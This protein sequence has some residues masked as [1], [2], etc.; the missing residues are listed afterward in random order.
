[1]DGRHR[2]LLVEDS[3][4]QAAKLRAV[5]EAQGWEVVWI[6]T[7]EAAIERINRDPPHLILLDYHLP[8]V[9]GDEFCRRI[10]MNIETRAIPVLML[11]ADDAPEAEVRG[12]ES[13]ADDFAPKSVDPDILTAR[14]RALLT[15]WR[16]GSSVLGRT[17][18]RFRAA[19]ILAIDDSLT[20]LEYLSE[21]LGREGYLLEKA[22][23]GREGLERLGAGAFDCV[24]VDLM[25]PEVDG[26]EVCRRI[27]ESRRSLDDPIA[28]LMLTARETKDDLTRALEAGADDFVGK[29]SDISVI[30]GRIRALLRRKFF[31][32]E[33]RR[34]LEEL[35]NKEMERVRARAEQTAAEAR[36]ALAEEL[37]AAKEAA[38]RADRAK[39]EF[40]SRMSHELRTPLNSILGFGQLLAMDELAGPQRESVD[41]ILKSG[42]HLLNLINEVLDIARIEAGRVHLS[43]EDVR[44]E[45]V[46]AEAATMIAPIA[47]Q[48]GVQLRMPTPGECDRVVRADVQR[49]KQAVLNLLSN[50]V[51]Y[52]R[53]GG[54]VSIS[55]GPTAAGAVRL[56]IADTGIGIPPEKLGRLFTAFE[57]L[58]AE[59]AGIEG[60]GLGLVLSKRLV[61]A[62]GGT[63]GA[64]SESG[65]G[66]VFWIDLPPAAEA[67]PAPTPA[68]RP[69]ATVG[70]PTA[71][72]GTVL[73]IEDNV[74]NLR[75]V[76]RVI[77]MRVG[78]GLLSAMQG[79]LG[80]ELARRHRPDLILL[81]LNL[82]DIPGHEVLARLHGDADTAAIPVV[83]VSADATAGAVERLRAAGAAAYLAKPIDVAEFLGILDAKLGS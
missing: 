58:D 62:M 81:D 6:A 24:L 25:M 77:G 53:A 54:S 69:A 39:S 60:T 78:V 41:Q 31:Q 65:K 68:P 42:R 64:Q 72:R 8:G 38:E 80:L 10:R 9:H 37:R 44:V 35:K 83:V 22:S 43:V 49:L 36:A 34:I 5:L 14:A 11:T 12:L 56:R 52:N 71:R 17:D 57:R 18:A 76:E 26:I 40:L 48:A 2:I 15:K 20:Y 66:S 28:V 70:A 73:Y 61:E 30:K 79:R 50:A 16:A 1:V 19:R 82:P 13:G 4:T 67:G 7:A 23:G 32:E 55:C 21:E 51:K 29:S 59:Q 33:N 45:Q 75:L 74:S 46:V 3:P 63:M 27:N 47:A